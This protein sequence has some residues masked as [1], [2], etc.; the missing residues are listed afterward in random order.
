MSDA[1]AY[2]IG[3]GSD[4][5]GINQ[6]VF[7]LRRQ[8]GSGRWED[9]EYIDLGPGFPFVLRAATKPLSRDEVI[10]RLRS[11]GLVPSTAGSD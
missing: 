5:Q 11:L 2:L 8:Y 1:Q 9:Y 3:G 7:K 10:A 4:G 6:C